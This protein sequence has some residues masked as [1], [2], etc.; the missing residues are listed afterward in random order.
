MTTM[1]VVPGISSCLLIT[2]MGYVG[3]NRETCLRE[4]RLPPQGSAATT[5]TYTRSWPTL[6]APGRVDRP[7]VHRQ[8]HN[9]QGRNQSWRDT[10]SP[11]DWSLHAQGLPETTLAHAPRRLVSAV[12]V[13]AACAIPAQSAWS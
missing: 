7:Y 2:P 1:T 12:P 4:T 13:V 5:P 10:P 8:R 6:A 11:P 3:Q 9:S